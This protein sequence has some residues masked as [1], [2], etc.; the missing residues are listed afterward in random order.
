[1]SKRRDC[2]KLGRI[3]RRNTL[4]KTFRPE[5]E[6]EEAE[7]DEVVEDVGRHPYSS[8]KTMALFNAW[9]STAYD[10][11]I[12]NQQSRK[13]FWDKVI[14]VYNEQKPR[15]TFKRNMKMLRSHFERADKDVKIFC[16]INKHEAENY[17]SGASGADI[18]R[19]AL[20]VYKADTGKDF[21]Y[22][23]VWQSVKELDRWAGGVQSSTGSSSK[24]TKHTAGGQYSS[25]EGGEG[26]AS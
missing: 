13:C 22:P 3:F 12:E 19:A 7:E 23:D 24:C 11:I 26:N 9:I 15:G 14:D 2:P 8:A 1:M 10:P 4:W 16:R 25:S 20:Q 18:L 21:N 5:L 6:E 17:Q